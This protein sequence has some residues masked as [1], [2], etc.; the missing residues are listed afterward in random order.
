MRQQVETGWQ[1]IKYRHWRHLAD[2]S[3]LTPTSFDAQLILDPFEM[4]DPQLRLM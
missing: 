1:L 4:K 2:N 3:A